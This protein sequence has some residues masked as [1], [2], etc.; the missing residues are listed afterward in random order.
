MVGF[1]ARALAVTARAILVFGPYMLGIFLLGMWTWKKGVLQ[2]P[3]EHLPLIRK[4]QWWGLAVGLLG[5]VAFLLVPEWVR[6]PQDVVRLVFAIG[7][8]LG[9][10]ALCLFYAASIV[11]LAAGPRLPRALAAVVPVGRM[12]L[13]NYFLQT[14][15]C[16]TLFYGYGLGLYGRT[17]PLLNLVVIAC[18][19]AVEIA[20][21]GLWLRRFR[22]GPAEWLWRSLTYGKIQ[23]LRL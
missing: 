5:N 7:F 22:F 2:R 12:A 18:V 16:T 4:V 6:G 17:G 19:F 11:R 1:R 3:G 10:P 20:A 8:L 23:P 14:L 13:S 15:L 21:S 9:N